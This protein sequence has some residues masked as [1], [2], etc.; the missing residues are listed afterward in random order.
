M[1]L[2]SD[3][4]PSA[5]PTKTLYT[6]LLSPTHATCPAHLILLDLVTWI[7]FGGVQITNYGKNKTKHWNFSNQTFQRD[8][9]EN[10]IHNKQH[11]RETPSHKTWNP[12][13]HLWQKRHLPTNMPR[14]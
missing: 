1:G 6:S 3:F 7:I 9:R 10:S 5:F 8:R 12:T 14:M 2:P 11:N 4:F 13:E